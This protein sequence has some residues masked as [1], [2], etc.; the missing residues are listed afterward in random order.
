LGIAGAENNA[1]SSAEEE[2]N[3][4]SAQTASVSEEESIDLSNARSCRADLIVDA[5]Y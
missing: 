4:V 2:F 5:A 3:G 1:M